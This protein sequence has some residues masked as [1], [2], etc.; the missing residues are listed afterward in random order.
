MI[1]LGLAAVY[2]LFSFVTRAEPLTIYKK[3]ANFLFYWYVLVALLVMVAGSLLAVVSGTG[4]GVLLGGVVGGV[5][6]VVAG[7]ALAFGLLL[8]VALAYILEIIGAFLLRESLTI[9]EASHAWH[10]VKFV[11]GALC[12]VVGLFAIPKIS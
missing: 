10:P 8:A 6:G 7:S 12:L 2:V 3:T 1:G 9:R 4:L 11:I 5:L